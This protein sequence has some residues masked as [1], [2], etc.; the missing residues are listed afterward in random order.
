MS[1][2]LVVSSVLRAKW[3]LPVPRFTQVP[4]TWGAGFDVMRQ[5]SVPM[6]FTEVAFITP[7]RFP[8]SLTR[9]QT[10]LQA[11]RYYG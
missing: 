7:L 6:G 3:G 5:V 4:R 2:L 8:T 9:V 11:N 10:C 1:Q